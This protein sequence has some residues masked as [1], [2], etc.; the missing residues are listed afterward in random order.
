MTYTSVTDGKEYELM[1]PVC[2]KDNG[3]SYD[4]LII[5][6]YEPEVPKMVGWYFDDTCGAGFAAEDVEYYIKQYREGQK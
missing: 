2:P 5:M 3:V 4:M 1:R 6:D